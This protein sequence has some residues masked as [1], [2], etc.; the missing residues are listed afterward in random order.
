VVIAPR[1]RAVTTVV[2]LSFATLSTGLSVFLFVHAA[3][4]GGYPF[5]HP[6]ELFCIR[7]GSLTELACLVSAMV[8]KG[9]PRPHVAVISTLDLLLWFLDAVAQ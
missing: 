1:W 2:G 6:G 5:Y 3:F 7:F 8:G 9:K 4:A